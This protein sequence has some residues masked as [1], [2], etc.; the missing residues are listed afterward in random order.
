MLKSEHEA[1][2]WFNRWK[3]SSVPIF[4]I[5]LR[6]GIFS[7]KFAARVGL[8]DETARTLI[9]VSGDNT[10]TLFLEDS[11]FDLEA[12]SE[13]PAELREATMSR[14]V[15]RINCVTPFLIHITLVEGWEAPDNASDEE[16][17]N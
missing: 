12:A 6:P 15:R 1:F 2:N 11:E 4:V 8:V 9:L 14:F 10:L 17:V 13:A 5:A 7:V 16:A 3:D